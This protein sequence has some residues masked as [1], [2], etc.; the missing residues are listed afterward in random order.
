MPADAL[1]GGAIVIEQPQSLLRW[2]SVQESGEVE[3]EGADA[4]VIPVDEPRARDSIGRGH[5]HVL[6]PEVAMQQR[7]RARPLHRPDAPWRI[8]PKVVQLV[9]QALSGSSERRW[10]LTR[11]D[12]QGFERGDGVAEIRR[13]VVRSLVAR[14][15]PDLGQERVAL[16]TRV[17]LGDEIDR[18]RQ[19]LRLPVYGECFFAEILVHVPDPAPVP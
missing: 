19:M 16:R 10:R 1:R 6:R 3:T 9:Q 7:L 8:L 2:G 18:G 5:E 4:D 14:A 13:E 17:E 12:R 15:P 11:R